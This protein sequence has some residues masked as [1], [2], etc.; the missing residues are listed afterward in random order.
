MLTDHADNKLV[1]PTGHSG[2]FPFPLLWIERN[3]CLAVCRAVLH[4]G[5]QVLPEKWVQQ[6]WVLL[7]W[8]FFFC[9][10]SGGIV[11]PLNMCNRTLGRRGGEIFRVISFE[12]LHLPTVYGIPLENQPGTSPVFLCLFYTFQITS[13]SAGKARDECTGRGKAGHLP[14]FSNQLL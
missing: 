7:C 9:T 12:G 8:F 14:V 11:L 1:A 5:H 4:D 2:I 3:S 6:Q 10:W 13:L